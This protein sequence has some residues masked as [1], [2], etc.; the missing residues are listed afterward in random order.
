MLAMRAGVGH[1][2]ALSEHVLI[3]SIQTRPVPV[4]LAD[5][6]VIDDVGD[7]DDG[8][9]HVEARFGYMDAPESPECS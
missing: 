6:V 7:T 9:T 4:L 1:V 3:L 8:L 5:R 2:D